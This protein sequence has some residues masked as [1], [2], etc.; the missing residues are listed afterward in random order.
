VP[1]SLVRAFDA[2]Q[3]LAMQAMERDDAVVSAPWISSLLEEQIAAFGTLNPY[4]NARAKTRPQIERMARHLRVQGLLSR[5]RALGSR[6]QRP[7]EADS[8]IPSAWTSLSTV[9]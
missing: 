2:G 5:G 9:S 8:L 3:Q 4:V 7:V 6:V 1:G